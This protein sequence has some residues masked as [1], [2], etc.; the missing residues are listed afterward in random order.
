MNTTAKGDTFELRVKAIIE[1]L[2]KKG[3]FSIVGN[4][5]EI[6]RKKEYQSTSVSKKV[7]VDL[8]IEVRRTEISPPSLYVFIECKDHKRPVSIDKLRV[9]NSVVQELAGW[10]V[11]AMFF[12]PS[13]LQNGAFEYAQTKKIAVVRV[14]EEDDLEWLIERTTDELVN[15][16]SNPE[17]TNVMHAI[18]TEYFV[19][20]KQNVFAFYKDKASYD[21][22]QIIQAMLYDI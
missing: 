21:V 3:E 13:S 18:S 19:S 6:F 7:I 15:T 8:S 17:I 22:G 14:L 12:T 4:F 20:T 11:K 5:I 10:N 9:F 16:Q 1:R 2:I